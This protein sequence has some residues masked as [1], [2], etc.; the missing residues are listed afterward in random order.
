LNINEIKERFDFLVNE[1]QGG[2]ISAE[3]FNMLFNTCQEDYYNFLKGNVESFQYGRPVPRVGLGMGEEIRSALSSFIDKHSSSG[4]SLGQL[5][6]KTEGS[7][8]LIDRI[9]H[10]KVNGKEVLP[11]EI[12]YKENAVNSTLVPIT[13]RPRYIE[14]PDNI[15][16]FGIEGVTSYDIYFMR[17]PADV[18]W[19]Y[20][21]VNGREIY[22]EEDSIHPEWKD[23]YINRII[24]R[25][26]RKFG[27][28]YKD[29]E[30]IQMG[31]NIKN[32][33]E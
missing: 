18:K 23:T 14:F 7:L 19:N 11:L 31:E 27:I 30:L 16:I 10:I 4:V 32:T 13:S 3:E 15:E 22:K 21:V 17:K 8:P 6:P 2:R 9:C 20:T 1:H 33:G 28:P 24:G 5:I 26:L 12:A 25:M 29:G